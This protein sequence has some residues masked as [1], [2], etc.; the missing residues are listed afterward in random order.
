MT[1]PASHLASRAELVRQ[2]GTLT[3]R[4]LR[5]A[6]THAITLS[7]ELDMAT[8][9]DLADE[10]QCVEATDARTIMLDLGGL[11]F[12]DSTG[13]RVLLQ[14]SAR[15]RADSDRLVLLRPADPV[16]RAFVISGLAARLPFA[17]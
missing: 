6:D 1:E 3:L 14:A 17:D 10:L 16:F 12:I 13:L 15:S 8:A 9:P 7:G 2:L 4:S 5:D 11:D